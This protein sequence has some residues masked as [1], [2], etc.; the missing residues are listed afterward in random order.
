MFQQK[1]LLSKQALV[2]LYQQFIANSLSLNLPVEKYIADHQ[3]EALFSIILQAGNAVFG[4][5]LYP[6]VIHQIAFI[7]FETVKKHILVDGNKRFGLFLALNLFDSNRM[8]HTQMSPDDWE[9]LVMRIASDSNYTV[10]DT[11]FFIK[12]KL[13]K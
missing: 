13:K 9:M 2:Y 6:S 1:P 4:R 7:L 10:K 8:E 5:K 3:I 12:K 11:Y